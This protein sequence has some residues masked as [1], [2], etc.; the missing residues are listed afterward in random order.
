MEELLK[1]SNLK[2]DFSINNFIHNLQLILPGCQEYF[3]NNKITNSDQIF[4]SYNVNNL[5]RELGID[6]ENISI[7]L[8]NVFD[9]Y[10]NNLSKHSNN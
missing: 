7:K 3:T 2:K 5:V 1:I 8:R 9:N 10:F 4:N 6:K